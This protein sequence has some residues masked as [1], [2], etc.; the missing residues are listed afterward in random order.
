ME[1]STKRSV[2]TGH[3][4]FSLKNN[5]A[6][7]D[8]ALQ[9]IKNKIFASKEL[10]RSIPWYSAPRVSATVEEIL[11][12]CNVAQEYEEDEYPRNLQIL[13]SKGERVVE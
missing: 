4:M 10:M 5:D 6:L 13:E 9:V 8:S 7:V 1:I 12:Y 11:D 2:K 3:V